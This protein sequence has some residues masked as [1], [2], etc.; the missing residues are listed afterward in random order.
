MDNIIKVCKTP[1]IDISPVIMVTNVLNLLTGCL[2]KID[3]KNKAISEN[4]FEKFI[5]YSIAWAIGGIYEAND[6]NLFHEYL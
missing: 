4:D 3:D 2:Y 6:R 5:I 1:V